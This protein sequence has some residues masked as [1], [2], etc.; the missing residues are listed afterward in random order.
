MSSPYKTFT[1][2]TFGCK[3]NF[4]DTSII[5][6]SIIDQGYSYVSLDDNPDI[7]IINTCTV[8][9]NADNKAKKMINK[10]SLANPN[11]NIIVTGCYAQLKPEEISKMSNVKYVVGLEDKFNISEFLEKTDNNSKII[12]RE[13]ENFNI[14]YSSDERT[15]S[16]VKIQDG[17]GYTCSY[18]TIPEARGKSRS[19]NVDSTIKTIIHIV[20]SG[21]KEIILSG[22]NVGDF[23]SNYNE[24]LKDLLV[25]IENIDDLQRYRISSIEPNLISD[26]LIDII[27]SSTKALPHFHI[28]MQSGSDNILRKMKRRYNSS[29]YK[30]IINNILTKVK[31]VSIGADVIVGFPSESEDDFNQTCEL[32][33]KIDL[34]YLHVFPYS[35]RANTQALNIYPKIERKEKIRRRNILMSISNEKN[36]K[37]INNNIGNNFNVLFESKVGEYWTGLTENYIRTYVKE[38]NCLKNKI[39]KIKLVSLDDLAIGEYAV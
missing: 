39:K 23:G 22:I 30:Q 31:N 16:F 11:C 2:Y 8:T 38:E 7:C 12:N 25:E 19:L 35:E 14:S 4:A 28:P 10:I 20:E 24:N 27:A 18:C 9:E 13:I 37:F 26:G 32:I 21:V 1:T 6:K 36:K 17:C 3:V 5:S 15:R 29:Q 34:S 33:N